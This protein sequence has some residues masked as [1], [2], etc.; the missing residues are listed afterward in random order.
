[1]N[2]NIEDG[3]AER[4]LLRGPAS[5]P[6]QERKTTVNRLTSTLGGEQLQV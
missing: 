3:E 2:V 4:A 6:T 1:M 5:V